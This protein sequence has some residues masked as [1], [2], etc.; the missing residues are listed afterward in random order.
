[1]SSA[2]KSRQRVKAVRKSELTIEVADVEPG[3]PFGIG[4]TYDGKWSDYWVKYITTDFGV[5]AQFKKMSVETYHVDLDTVNQCHR[6]NC[7][8][9]LRFGHCKHVEAAIHL[10]DAGRLLPAPRPKGAV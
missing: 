10:L 3:M 7:L 2:T 4:F 9:F 8:V 1:M 5:T 6:C